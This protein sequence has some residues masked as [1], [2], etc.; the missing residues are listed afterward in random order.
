[1]V[2]PGRVRL[3]QG[4]ESENELT[5]SEKKADPTA[6]GQSPGRPPAGFPGSR[7]QVVLG[8]VIVAD[9]KRAQRLEQ[10][11][12]EREREEARRKAF[13]AEQAPPRK[14]GASRSPTD[15]SCQ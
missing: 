7:S 10:E 4:E 6:P 13:E 9:A 8:L 3:Y 14:G 12:A 2:Q 5:R 11:R 15:E 1:V